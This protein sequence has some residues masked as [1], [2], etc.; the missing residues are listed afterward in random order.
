MF[1]ALQTALR[2]LLENTTKFEVNSELQYARM[3]EMGII[4][5]P[6]RF[7]I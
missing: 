5:C 2:T 4:S 3:P 1:R 7:E 6:L